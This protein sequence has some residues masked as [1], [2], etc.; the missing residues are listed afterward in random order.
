MSLASSVMMSLA[1]R[2]Y[3]LRGLLVPVPPCG[4]MAVHVA[5]LCKLLAAVRVPPLI[6]LRDMGEQ[7]LLLNNRPVSLRVSLGDV[8]TLNIKIMLNRSGHADG[9]QRGVLHGGREGVL[10][11]ATL[12]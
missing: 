2:A 7:D 1:K 11:I 3:H 6:A 10:K 4:W 12:L 8:T 9:A 5:N